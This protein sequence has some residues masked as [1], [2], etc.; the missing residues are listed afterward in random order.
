MS[1]KN[2]LRQF[3]IFTQEAM[4]QSLTQSPPTCVQWLDN[5]G[6]QF[7]F[8]GNPQGNFNVEVSADYAQDMNGQVQNP[9][10]WVAITLNP[11]P[12][13]NGIPDS[14]YIDIT[15]T[16]APWIRATF[17]NTMQESA[18]ITAIADVM[19]SLNS[20]YF[21]I[22]GSDGDNWYVWYDNGTGVDPMV[23]GRTGIHVT[24]TTGDTANTIATLTRS[25]LAACTS[26]EN[27]AGATSHITFD[28]V[29]PGSGSIADGTAQ[30]HFTF[31]YTANTG[32]LDGFIT[33]KMI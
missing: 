13:A 18:D 1:R 24:Y 19:D 9:G 7:N 15:Q 12:V 33:A 23:A 3:Q 8:T 17:T 4:N 16:S 28:Q 5:I 29:E 30:T 26:I 20:T 2:N 25:A 11:Q 32:V 21:L 31:A 14:V 22:N 27:I 10:N 6:F